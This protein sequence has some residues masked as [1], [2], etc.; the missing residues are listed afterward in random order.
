MLPSRME[1]KGHPIGSEIV[2]PEN[3]Y[4]DKLAQDPGLTAKIEGWAEDEG[5]GSISYSE[6]DTDGNITAEY[7][8][9]NETILTFTI[10]RIRDPKQANMIL[11]LP[12]ESS[13]TGNYSVYYETGTFTIVEVYDI[14]VIQVIN[15]DSIDTSAN[16]VYAYVP[17]LD[18]TGTNLTSPR[19]GWNNNTITL[20]LGG[21]GTDAVT[22]PRLRVPE[23]AKLTVTQQQT[24][25]NPNYDD[26]IT[27]DNKPYEENKT[28][29]IIEGVDQ[30]YA[31]RFIHNRISLPV[32]AMACMDQS[33]DDARNVNTLYMQTALDSIPCR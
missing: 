9:E 13:F 25:A 33:D 18:L 22:P 31:I 17:T 7:K 5:E 24:P 4:K 15:N 10:H 32:R 29:C 14:D 19:T 23:G 8:L 26:E 21:T 11:R 16:P 6:P 1:S 27:I 30:Y 20:T 28:V 2:T 3:K 12:G